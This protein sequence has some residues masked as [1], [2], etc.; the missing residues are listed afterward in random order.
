MLTWFFGFM[1]E[2][3]D[4]VVMAVKQAYVDLGAGGEVVTPHFPDG[5][6]W[7]AARADDSPFDGA[8]TFVELADSDA[9]RP[10]AR[11]LVDNVAR[12]VASA[13]GESVGVW[14]RVGTAKLAAV[15]M[16][17]GTVLSF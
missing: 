7:P 16:P 13:T 2:V 4:L 9:T 15:G 6:M 5:E 12:N 8:N 10:I 11:T 14:M 17:D 3:R 1:K